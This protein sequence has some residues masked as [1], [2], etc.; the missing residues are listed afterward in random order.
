MVY[1]LVVLVDFIKL[2]PSK[3]RFVIVPMAMRMRL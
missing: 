3:N 1:Y 2:K